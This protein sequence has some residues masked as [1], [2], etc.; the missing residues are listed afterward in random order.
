MT[1]VFFGDPQ[2]QPFLHLVVLRKLMMLVAHPD[3]FVVYP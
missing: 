1:M 2:P 3:V